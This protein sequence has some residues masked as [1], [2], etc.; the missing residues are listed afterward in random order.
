ME[1][2]SLAYLFGNA[3]HRIV[4]Y[5]TR[6]KTGQINTITNDAYRYLFIITNDWEMSEKQVIEFYNA[7]GA[8]EKIFDLQNNDFNWNCMPHSFLEQN[9]VSLILMA[10]AHIV[11]KWLL[12]IFSELI[13]GLT[14]TSRLKK[15]IF[16]FVAMVGKITKRGR[17]QI[18]ALATENQK[19][20]QAINTS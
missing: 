18:I 17:R 20:I 11:Y 7:R 12:C 14:S 8:S 9:T 13:E 3:A 2:T 10:I 1:V 16:R 19:L 15:F 5:R 4:G 6:N